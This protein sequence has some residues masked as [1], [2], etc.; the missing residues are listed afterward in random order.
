MVNERK[1][2]SDKK[3]N[4]R[5]IGG[6][7]CLVNQFIA[8]MLIHYMK[9][10][11]LERV[12]FIVTQS[13]F[14][15]SLS[16]LLLGSLALFNFSPL[17]AQAPDE[18]VKL[19]IDAG[20]FPKSFLGWSVDVDG[21]TA[22]VGAPRQVNEN[23]Y[24]AGAAYVYTRSGELWSLEQRLVSPDS[25]AVNDRFGYRV[26][27]SG[28]TLLVSARFDDDKGSN[29]GAAYVYT[30]S[31]DAWSYKQKLNASDGATNDQFGVS[32]QITSDWAFIGT[33]NDSYDIGGDPTEEVGVG[34]VY[35]FQLSGGTWSEVSKL[36]A[37]DAHEGQ[38]FGADISVS[39]DTA[40]IGA[41]KDNEVAEGAGA[42]YVFTHSGN[43]WT[44]QAK[45]T[46]SDGMATD[47]LGK[48]VSISGDTIILGAPNGCVPNSPFS[49]CQ[50]IDLYA[51]NKAYVFVRDGGSWTEQA[52][53]TSSTGDVGDFFG[54]STIFDDTVIIGAD[55]D[56][57]SGLDAGA[58]YLFTR[59]D[60]VWTE[61]AKFYASDGQDN[62]WFGA[63]VAMDGDSVL[64]AAP[65]AFQPDSR[66]G[67][68][69]VFDLGSGETPV[70]NDIVVEPVTVDSDGEPVEDA[71]NINLGFKKV[72]DGGETTIVAH[73][74]PPPGQELPD[75]FK[76]TGLSGGATYFDIHTEAEFTGLVEICID[77]SGLA[78]AGN[79]SK[80]KFLHY[81]TALGAWEN[82]TSS[83]DTEVMILCGL[84]DSFSLF[85]IAEID[86]P[87]ELLSDLLVAVSEVN[88]NNGIINALDKK[89]QAVEQALQDA[90]FENDF[91]ALSVLLNAFIN[92]VEAQ[93]DKKVSGEEADMLI[94]KAQEIAMVL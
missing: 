64:I 73:D 81:D 44:Q 93:R 45:L 15:K 7:S 82:I 40:V 85:G 39:G 84:T 24:R 27:V 74:A 25:S 37:G 59:T 90:S 42:G 33:P 4:N 21:N 36:Q 30:R 88:A 86:D 65:I 41:R 35:V 38:Y 53:L 14:R 17:W 54:M 91:A 22:V 19:T 56:D 46:A 80:L 32:I 18:V 5:L 76:L 77:Y 9:L 61:S 47:F 2:N 70:G 89:L 28:D 60:G 92:S 11:Q 78:I 69:Y 66:P 34:S 67:S 75:G 72:L 50:S 16:S 49:S 6:I 31:D 58:A 12:L 51:G 26:S 13:F 43:S 48:S 62:E 83:N 10:K 57:D 94:E 52:K 8:W 23:G 1:G 3:N 68:A 29:S 87:V 63:Q 20:A 79:P 71:P 55:G